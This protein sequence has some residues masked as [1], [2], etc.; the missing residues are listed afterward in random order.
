VQFCWN[1]EANLPSLF[2]LCLTQL[3]QQVII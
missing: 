2:S 1:C 3:K